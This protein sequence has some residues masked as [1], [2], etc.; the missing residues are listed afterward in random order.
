MNAKI[1]D[2]RTRR[3]WTEHSQY[4]LER[5][6]LKDR[7]NSLITRLSNSQKELDKLQRTNV[8]SFVAFFLLPYLSPFFES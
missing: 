2:S 5:E 3:F 1:D 7:Q 4:V 6:V 8:Y